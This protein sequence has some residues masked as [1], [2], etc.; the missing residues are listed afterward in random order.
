[1][2]KGRKLDRPIKTRECDIAM[3]RAKGIL[4]TCEK[5]CRHCMCCIETDYNGDREHVTMRGDE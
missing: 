3:A 4:K 1:M 2:A 5:D